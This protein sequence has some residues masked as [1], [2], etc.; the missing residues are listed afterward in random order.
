M[1]KDF[2]RHFLATIAYRARKVIIDSPAD[3]GTFDAGHGVRKPV[4]ILSHMSKVLQHARSFFITT[5]TTRISVGTWEQEVERFFRVLS[6][7]D[8]L[9]EAGIEPRGRT[10]EQLLQGP[11]ADAMTHI[12]QLAMLRRMASSPIPKEDFDEATIRLGDVGSTQ[13]SNLD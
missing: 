2:L 6:E 4:E 8:K 7:L 12:G 5:E 10:V 13:R 11:L 3:F 1:K 9:L